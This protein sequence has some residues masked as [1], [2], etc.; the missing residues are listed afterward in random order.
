MARNAVRESK[1]NVRNIGGRLFD[2]YVYFRDTFKTASAEAEERKG[3]TPPE[4]RG[5]GSAANRDPTQNRRAGTSATAAAD[6]PRVLPRPCRCCG[7]RM[8]ITAHNRARTTWRNTTIASALLHGGAMTGA[9]LTCWPTACALIGTP[10][11][12]CRPHLTETTARP[13]APHPR[14]LTR[15]LRSSTLAC[16]LSPRGSRDSDVSSAT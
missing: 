9:T 8:I 5:C 12:V 13:F 10:F 11:D 15:D 6:E 2:R 3:R 4:T 7:G 14:H 16:P 1:I